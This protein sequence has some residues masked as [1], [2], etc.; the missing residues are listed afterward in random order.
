MP[1]PDWFKAR[2]GKCQVHGCDY[3]EFTDK[4][5]K[6]LKYCP[7]CREEAAK[8]QYEQRERGLREGSKE[9]DGNL[10]GETQK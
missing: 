10:P 3:M 5:K 8:Q 9:N 6:G 2:N 7:M 4:R 1:V